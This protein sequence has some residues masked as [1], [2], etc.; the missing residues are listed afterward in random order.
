MAGTRLIVEK[1]VADRLTAAILELDR[2]QAAH[3]IR[4]LEHAAVVPQVPQARDRILRQ[5][6]RRG[7][8]GG[9][10]EP[11][12]GD[13]DRELVEAAVLQQRGSLVDDFL[14]RAGG[15]HHGRQRMG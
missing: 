10:V 15:H 13:R 5:H 14:A 7:Q 2:R 6:V 11:R 8:V 9:I 1:S 3:S 12:R 4:R